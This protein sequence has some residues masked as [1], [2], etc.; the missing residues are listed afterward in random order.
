MAATARVTMTEVAVLARHLLLYPTGV[1]QESP[2]PAAASVPRQ[3]TAPPRTAPPTGP[4]GPAHTPLTGP[5]PTPV[6]VADLP[7]GNGP[8]GADGQLPV[9]LLHGFV[10][11]RSVFT[12][13]RRNLRRHGWRQVSALNYSP[14]TSDVRHAAALLGRHVE[15]LCE[16]TGSA[17]I[18]LVGHSLGGLIGRYYAQRLGGDVRVRTLVTLATPHAGTRAVPFADPHPVVRQM[19]PRSALMAELALPAPGC[20]TR[21]VAFWSDADPIMTPTESARLDHPDLIIENV[22]VQGVGHLAM[23]VNAQVVAGVR[24]ALRSVSDASEAV[25]AA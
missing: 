9:L 14:L 25:D 22:G 7:P 24:Q 13:L 20:R 3:R 4:S 16:R 12:P 21:F 15:E 23:A 8:V 6:P 18:D 2:A 19:R 10:D 17:R 1:F 5:V 11:N